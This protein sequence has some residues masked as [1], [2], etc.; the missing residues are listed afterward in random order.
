MWPI[1][2]CIFLAG[3]VGSCGLSLLFPLVGI[4]TYMMIYQLNPDDTWWGQPLEEMELRLSLTAAVCMILGMLLSSARVP[5]CKEVVGDWLLLLVTF[6]VV[7]LSSLWIGTGTTEYGDMLADK[8]VKMTIFL[9]CMVRM[10]GTTKNFRAVLWAFAI[11]TLYI[12]NEAFNAASSDFADGRLNFIGGPDFRESSGLAVHMAAML[13]LLGILF[14]TVKKW[15]WKAL[16]L[17]AG[18]LA[19]NTVIQCRTRSAFVGLIA[20]TVVALIMLPRKRRVGVGASIVTVVVGMYF[21]TDAHFWERMRTIVGHETYA[22]EGAIQARLELWAAAW[23]MFLDHPFGVGVG[24]FKQAVEQY[25]TGVEMYAFSVPRRVTHNSYL[26]CMTELGIQ[27]VTVFL[28]LFTLTLW[29]LRQCWRWARLSTEA[30]EI[31]MFAFGCLVSITIYVVAAGFTDRLY[32]ESFWWVLALPVCLERA[33]VRHYQEELE[34]AGAHELAEDGLRLNDMEAFDE[35]PDAPV[36]DFGWKPSPRRKLHGPVRH[37]SPTHYTTHGAN[38]ILPRFS[39]PMFSEL[40]KP[41]ST[42]RK[43]V[44]TNLFAGQSPAS[45]KPVLKPSDTVAASV[46]ALLGAESE[47]VRLYDLEEGV[48]KR[49]VRAGAVTVSYRGQ[50]SDGTVIDEANNTRIELNDILPELALGIRTMR[51]AGRRRIVIPP[52]SACDET[53]VFDVTLLRVHA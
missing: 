6:T 21:L 13:P 20:G 30:S 47:R 33:A 36:V 37:L 12:G 24:Q 46:E 31:R 40:V 3:F 19:A 51:E 45:V 50:L 10:G 29:K 41:H 7:V 48:G 25:N 1:K 53:V 27:G 11:G 18:V 8:M 28:A 17:C 38:D 32:T 23:K 22:E 42:A 52:N 16:L 44:P 39:T 2:T 49:A 5:K 35:D 26:L 43:P 4:I 34:Q 9:F 15:R 14:L